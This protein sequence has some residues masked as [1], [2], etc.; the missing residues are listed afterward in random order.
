MHFLF[1][2]ILVSLFVTET[3]GFS[4]GGVVTAGYLALFALQFAGWLPP[5]LAPLLRRVADARPWAV[6]ILGYALA[7]ILCVTVFDRA[8]GFNWLLGIASLMLSMLISV[9]AS[10]PPVRRATRIDPAIV[11]R[12]E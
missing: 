8:L 3:T 7:R 5:R 1:I 10:I 12:E 11:L 4:P 6:L 9:I 2:G